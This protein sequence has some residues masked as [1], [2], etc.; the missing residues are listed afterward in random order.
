MSKLGSKNVSISHYCNKP[1]SEDNG[2]RPSKM[3]KLKSSLYLLLSSHLIDCLPALGVAA[4]FKLPGQNGTTHPSFQ[5]VLQSPLHV[6][7]HTYGLICISQCLFTELIL[8]YM[9][10]QHTKDTGV[11]HEE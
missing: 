1:I 6:T 10:L 3:K 4:S 11:Q 5:V 7:D 9:H 2:K 8:L